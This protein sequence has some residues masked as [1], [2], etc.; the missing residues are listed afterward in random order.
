MSA[1]PSK[2]GYN[3]SVRDCLNSWCKRESAVERTRDPIYVVTLMV[4]RIVRV[5]LSMR[6]CTA[7]CPLHVFRARVS[8]CRTCPP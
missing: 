3:I 5:A 8:N 6:V 2:G 4:P 7:S 1:G